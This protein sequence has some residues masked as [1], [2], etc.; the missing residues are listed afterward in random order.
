MWGFPLFFGIVLVMFHSTRSGMVL[1]VTILISAVVAL[2]L[3][4]AVQLL[5]TLGL[6]AQNLEGREQAL[7]AARSGLDY[8]RSRLQADPSWRGDGNSLVVDT[9]EFKVLEDNGNVFGF[10]TPSDGKPSYFRF[11]FNYQN[12]GD[13]PEDSLPDPEFFIDSEFVSYNNLRRAGRQ[14]QYRAIPAGGTW[15]V[16]DSSPIPVMVPKFTSTIIVE[17]FSGPAVS[18]VNPGS[19]NLSPG[20]Q[21]FSLQVVEAYFTRPGFLAV[22]SA[23]MAA[24]TLDAHMLDGGTMK[25]ESDQNSAPPRVR[26]LDQMEVYALA[27]SAD[28]QTDANGE[29]IVDTD[30]E[31]LLNGAVSSS[32][33]ASHESKDEQSSHWLKLGF[34]DVTRATA[35]DANLKA[36]TYVWKSKV[37]G[38]QL[39]YFPMDYTGTVPT[40]DGLVITNGD[41]MLLTGS[42]AIDLTSTN[43]RMRIKDNVF[44]APHGGATGFAVVAE[45]GF[46]SAL[47]RR[48]ETILNHTSDDGVILSN[49]NGSIFLEGKIDGGGAVTSS[50]DITFQGTSA[51]EA[52]K[53]MAVALYA[54]GDINLKAIPEETIPAILS[55]LIIQGG[56]GGKGKGGAGKGKGGAPQLPGLGLQGSP[57]NEPQDVVFGGII[58]AQGNFNV[59]LRHQDQA[60]N[61]IGSEHGSI[62]VKGILATFGG[63]PET[64][65]TPGTDGR[66]VMEMV[67]AEAAF[68]YDPD[69][70][71]SLVRL[72]APTRLEK[73]FWTSH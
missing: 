47:G 7:L 52:D 38:P 69:Y 70:L 54:K 46:M 5:P 22:D 26:A 41:Q 59:D 49:D 19:P 25:V 48:P 68:V 21:K 60:G 39:E 65:E 30:K 28:Y 63:D 64:Q 31:F 20:N 8:A 58:F 29:V 44:V 9:P 33:A 2:F 56:G 18:S 55:G 45:P 34:D 37:G 36:G 17:G 57:F 27:G 3:A 50:G 42:D 51:L 1:V 14:E 67:A 11:R 61:L 15:K 40:G 73:S 43:F 35:S 32:P 16:T 13:V 6:S 66:G 24:A 72:D 71:D 10:L 62:Y 23:V 53:D 4:G 12:G